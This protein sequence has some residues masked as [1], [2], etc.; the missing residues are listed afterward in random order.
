MLLQLYIVIACIVLLILRMK[1]NQHKQ[2]KR[3][4]EYNLPIRPVIDVIHIF[5]TSIMN[6]NNPDYNPYVWIFQ[7]LCANSRIYDRERIYSICVAGNVFVHLYKPEFIKTI[8]N[9]HTV[10]DKGL[11]YKP[12][13]SWLGNGLITRSRELWK[14]RRKLLTPAFH[15]KILESF[16]TV[17]N[18]HCFILIDKLE[19]KVQDPW[20]NITRMLSL[21]TLD[22]IA[23]TAMGV[24]IN[25]QRDE[26]SEYVKNVNRIEELI[27]LRNM[28]PWMWSDMLFSISSSGREFNRV[29]NTVH[30]FTRKVI[31]ERKQEMQEYLKDNKVSIDEDSENVYTQSKNRKPF[32]T[33]LLHHHLNNGDITEEDIREEVDTFMLAGHDTTSV[34]ISWTLYNLGLYP[35][36]QQKVYDEVVSV[37][38]NDKRTPITSEDI[39]EMKYLECVIKESLRLYPPVPF[40]ARS[41]PEEFKIGDKIMPKNAVV[42]I[43][44]HSIHRDPEFYPDPESFKPE[45]FYPENCSE[46]N[47]FAYIPFSAGS[48]NCIGQRFALMEEKVVIANVLRY[49]RIY[50]KEKPD[51]MIECGQLVLRSVNGIHLKFEKRTFK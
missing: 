2:L 31:S 15:F 1:W 45:R 26:E 19:K 10:L 39:K 37:C 6:R 16:H 12:I 33:L 50:A 22:I 4:K 47:P 18:K 49:F 44:I 51:K 5:Y 8:I 41:H 17:I 35:D 29:L 30:N 43:L 27:L 20:V 24:E 28:H 42:H 40:I 11:M 14:P 25:A 9:S 48:R 36:I 46:R 7:Y 23:E 38:G 13:N 32:L 3:L 21:C 34:G